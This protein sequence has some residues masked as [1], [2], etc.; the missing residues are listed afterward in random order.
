[1]NNL[2]PKLEELEPI[3]DSRQTFSETPFV[4]DF[5]KLEESEQLQVLADIVKQTM[6]YNK[7]NN[8]ISGEL[9]LMGDDYTSSK[10][11]ANYIKS[12]CLYKDVH[13]VMT[14]NKKNIDIDNYYDCHFS[15]LVGG[16]SGKTYLVDSTPDIGYGIGEVNNLAIRDL[17][18]NYV[19]L[20]ENMMNIIELIRIDMYNIE[21]NKYHESQISDYKLFKTIFN[22]KLFDGLLLE[23]YNCVDNSNYSKLKEVVKFD[24]QDRINYINDIKCKNNI[25]KIEVIN[26]WNSHLSLLSDLNGDIK[27]TQRLA[28]YICSEANIKRYM[29]INNNKI[30]L[31]HISPRLLWELGFNVIIIKPSS[32]LVGIESSTEDYM[33]YKRSNFVTSYSCNM[34]KIGNYSLKPMAYFHPHGMKYEEQMNGPNKIILVNEQAIV[35]NERKHYIRNNMAQK[36]QGHFVNWFNEEKIIWDT[37]LNTNL[38]HSTDDSVEASIHLLAGYP[39]Y[40][41]FT[42]FNYPNPVL[43]KEKRK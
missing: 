21:N 42:R 2:L 34:G 22:N 13:I 15:T 24:Y 10:V 9:L 43:R 29:E 28:Q 6:I 4:R 23:Y 20:D 36:I 1:M 5:C 25:N 31:N 41:S 39:E 3:F 30:E 38:V 17:F 35:L 11:F 16:N 27:E 7:K 33:L 40:Q 18:N 8:P 37:N 19:V 26:N 12:L 14:T 32:F